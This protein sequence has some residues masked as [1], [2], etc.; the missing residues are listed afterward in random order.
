MKGL[1]KEGPLALLGMAERKA[2]LRP[3]PAGRAGT[4][5]DDGKKTV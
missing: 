1:R 4:L 2:A 5:S 3:P